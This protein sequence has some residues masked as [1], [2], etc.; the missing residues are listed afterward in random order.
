MRIFNVRDYGAAGDGCSKDTLPIQRTIDACSLAGGGV[1][2]VPPGTYLSGTLYLKDNLCLDI[3][4][5]AVLLGSTEATDYNADDF[6]S[7][8]RVFLPE[9][10]SGAHLVVGVEVKNVTIR[11]G[12]RI[13]GNGQAFFSVPANHPDRFEI[14]GWRPGQMVFLCECENI[15]IEDVELFNAPYWSCFLHGCDRVFVRGV[16]VWNDPRTINGDGIDIDCCRQVVISDCI[17]ESG[18]DCI[19]L[20]GNAQPLKNPKPC[21]D[22]V[23]NNCI[24][25]TRANGVRVG[26]G[27]G[28][29]RQALFSN[30]II[31]GNALDG[32]CIQS[33]YCSGGN[34][35]GHGGVEIHDL[36]FENIQMPDVCSAMYVAPGYAGGQAVSRLYFHNLHAMAKKGSVI[37]GAASNLLRHIILSRIDIRTSGRQEY[38]LAPERWETPVFEWDGCMPAALY[39]ADC[40][41]IEMDHCRLD[42]GDTEGAWRHTLWGRRLTNCRIRECRLQPPPGTTVA[43]QLDECDNIDVSAFEDKY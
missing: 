31:G 25:K 20:R 41:D 30:L 9:K 11:G 3:S 10:V 1:V 15:R 32:I 4:P 33:N 29:I 43:L 40:D 19:T 26:V 14:P 7:Q 5:G 38:L 12:G 17:I 35:T 39:M 2:L 13:D 24:L 42:W 23:V 21:E 27:N 6:C 8:N 28:M 16:R 37:K 36:R 18:D 22:V 34:L